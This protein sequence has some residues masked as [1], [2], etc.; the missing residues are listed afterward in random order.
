[1]CTNRDTNAY[2][3]IV[4]V[5]PTCHTDILMYIKKNGT[6]VIFEKMPVKLDGSSFLQERARY[7]SSLHM[8]YIEDTKHHNISYHA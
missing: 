6:V 2:T 4:A 5:L 3:L 8:V 7:R 1:M